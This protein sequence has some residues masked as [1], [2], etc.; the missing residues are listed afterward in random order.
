MKAKTEVIWEDPPGPLR[1]G[2]VSHLGVAQEL[3]DNPGRWGIVKVHGKAQ[4][5]SSMANTIRKG[6]TGAWKPAGAFEA[7]ARTV[8]GEHRVY[9]RYVGEK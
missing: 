1:T 8:N 6:V 4:D 3:R 5:S 2:S 9:A 7:A